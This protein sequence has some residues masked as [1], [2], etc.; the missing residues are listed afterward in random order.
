MCILCCRWFRSYRDRVYAEEDL[1]EEQEAVEQHVAEG[2]PVGQTVATGVPVT[3]RG[4]DQQLPA[5]NQEMG[6]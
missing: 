5:E 4:E 2:G 6:R 1:R 3:E